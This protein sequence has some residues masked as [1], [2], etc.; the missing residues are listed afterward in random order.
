MSFRIA[1]CILAGLLPGAAQMPQSHPPVPKTGKAMTKA[2]PPAG[3]KVVDVNSATVQ[4][5]MLLPG[6][7]EELARKI[8]KGRPYKTKANLVTHQILPPQVYDVVKKHI[9]ARQPGDP[10]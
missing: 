10:K 7:T 1:A 5:L 8:I 4:D 6:I 3:F 2:K 9:K